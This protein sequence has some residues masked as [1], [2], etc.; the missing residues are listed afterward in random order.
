MDSLLRWGIENSTS[1]TNGPPPPPG[2]GQP[3]DPGII[4]AIL[5]KPDSQL[6]K[7]AMDIAVDKQK[8][9][10]ERVAALD[11]LEMVSGDSTHLNPRAC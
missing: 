8:S 1:S 9:E 5:G 2:N 11:D 4:D 6:M 10:D 3:L 7:E